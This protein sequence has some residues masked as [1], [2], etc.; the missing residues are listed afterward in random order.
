[1]TLSLGLRALV[2]GRLSASGRLWEGFVLELGALLPLEWCKQLFGLGLWA[3]PMRAVAQGFGAASGRAAGALDP[4]T[5]LFFGMGALGGALSLLLWTLGALGLIRALGH[6][7]GRRVLGVM[8]GASA[9]QV[10]ATL[11]YQARNPALPL[12]NLLVPLACCLPLVAAGLGALADAL[13][14]ASRARGRY[15]LAGLGLLLA[16]ALAVP[17]R[18]TPGLE[19]S[20]A[21]A[22]AAAAMV[23]LVAEDEPVVASFTNAPLAMRA[24]RTWVPWP[25][26][27]DPLSWPA[28]GGGRRWALLSSLD[29]G[30]PAP[31]PPGLRLA[32]VRLYRGSAGW[33]ALAEI[34]DSTTTP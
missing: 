29:G 24:G 21:G 23:D 4:L 33:V 16:A 11:L 31:L 20:A 34:R 30:R 2:T 32:P 18:L 15:G 13:P 3:P 9:A 17:A 14:A 12:S 25:A 26:P 28:A 1:M 19:L 27:W 7:E 8:A 10:A 6:R 5:A 22:Q